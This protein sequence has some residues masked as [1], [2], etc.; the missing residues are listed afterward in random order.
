M[1]VGGWRLEDL[2]SYIQYTTFSQIRHWK[3]EF[4]ELKGKNRFPSNQPSLGDERNT[5]RDRRIGCGYPKETSPAFKFIL[6]YPYFAVLMGYLRVPYDVFKSKKLPFKRKEKRRGCVFKTS[7]DSTIN[8]QSEN[9]SIKRRP[10][11]MD[12]RFGCSN[13]GSSQNHGDLVNKRRLS[14]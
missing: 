7:N 9:I 11:K 5:L 2:W 13:F 14:Q 6:Y 1:E 8:E 4:K 3:D 10:L 12:R